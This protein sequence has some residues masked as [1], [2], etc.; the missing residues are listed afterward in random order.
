[1]GRKRKKRDKSG[2][3]RSEEIGERDR[4][5]GGRGG[6]RDKRGRKK[7]GYRTKRER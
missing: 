1:M 6:M 4:R 5:R 2:T 3:Q 7:C